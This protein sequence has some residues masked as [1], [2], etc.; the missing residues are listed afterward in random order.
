MVNTAQDNNESS[1]EVTLST[2]SIDHLLVLV[3]AIKVLQ[4]EQTTIIVHLNIDE[5]KS[6]LQQTLH[7]NNN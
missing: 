1:I 5:D 7:K 4:K 6:W 2:T 3:T